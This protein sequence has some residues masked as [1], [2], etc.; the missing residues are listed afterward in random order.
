MSR[1]LLSDKNF[2]RLSSYANRIG[3]D[4]LNRVLANW[5]DDEGDLQIDDLEDRIRRRRSHVRSRTH[6]AEVHVLASPAVKK[7]G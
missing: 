6:T 5:M 3:I 1:T 4:T 7:A 2:K